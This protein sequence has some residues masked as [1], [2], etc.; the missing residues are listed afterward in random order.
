M[1]TTLFNSKTYLTAQFFQGNCSIYVD[2]VSGSY[3]TGE[4]STATKSIV[5]HYD[6][7]NSICLKNSKLLTCN[8]SVI[9]FFLTQNKLKYYL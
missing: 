4:D 9:L 7:N 2:T 5:L 6:F 8:L 1:S 3:C